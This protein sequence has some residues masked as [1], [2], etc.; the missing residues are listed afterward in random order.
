MITGGVIFTLTIIGA[1]IGI[2]MIG[3]GCIMVFF[4]SRMFKKRGDAMLQDIDDD[5]LRMAGQEAAIRT[6]EQ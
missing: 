5:A 6:I 4:F 3:V 2:P 1:I